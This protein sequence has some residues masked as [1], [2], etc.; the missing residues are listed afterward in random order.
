MAKGSG[1]GLRRGESFNYTGCLPIAFH[2][3]LLL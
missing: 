1:Y 2:L 3:I